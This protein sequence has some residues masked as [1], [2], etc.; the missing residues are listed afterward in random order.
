MWNAHVIC[1]D[2]FPFRTDHFPV[3]MYIVCAK[4]GQL[5][6]PPTINIKDENDPKEIFPRDRSWLYCM[7][8]VTTIPL[9]LTNFSV[10]LSPHMNTSML[11]YYIDTQLLPHTI[12]TSCLPP[13]APPP[14]PC[15]ELS[16]C[17]WLVYIPHLVVDT[18][19]TQF[20][21]NGPSSMV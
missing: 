16:W 9:P 15:I 4:W 12:Q 14:P 11:Q 6:S 2:L 8:H 13:Q 20:E 1:S 5:M 18:C 7:Y 19:I 17:S 3:R 21:A 10:S